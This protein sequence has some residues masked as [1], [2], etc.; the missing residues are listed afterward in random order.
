MVV[1]VVVLC[2]RVLS[3]QRFLIIIISVVEARIEGVLTADAASRR[4]R[5]SR[6]AKAVRV[7]AAVHCLKLL[8][9][10]HCGSMLW[11]LFGRIVNE[12]GEKIAGRCAGAGQR[13]R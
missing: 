3:T 5:L 1:V 2:A 12:I 7:D 4:R 10:F 9:F 6:R 8:L 11:L 13:C